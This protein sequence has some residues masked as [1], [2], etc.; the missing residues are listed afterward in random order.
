M[1]EVWPCLGSMETGCEKTGTV[2]TNW[3]YR[4]KWKSG[5][6]FTWRMWERHGRWDRGVC[7]RPHPPFFC[8][9]MEEEGGRNTDAETTEFVWGLTRH[10]FCSC[11]LSLCVVCFLSG[12]SVV[13]QSSPALMKLTPS[14]VLMRQQQHTVYLLLSVPFNESPSFAPFSCHMIDQFDFLW[15][16]SD[17]D[18]CELRS[19]WTRP[20]ELKFV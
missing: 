12:V 18:V 6:P 17:S 9:Y 13:I 1:G 5:E 11:L 15:T 19:V 3:E 8:S 2:C 16:S 10:S 14:P 4:C 20:G 7:L